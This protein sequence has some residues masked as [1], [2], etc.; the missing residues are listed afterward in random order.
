[1]KIHFGGSPSHFLLYL[2]DLKNAF[3]AWVY[4]RNSNKAVGFD[5]TMFL[6]EKYYSELDIQA[7][8]PEKNEILV[9]TRDKEKNLVL[10]NY[11]SLLYKKLGSGM[12]A[13]RATPDMDAIYMLAERNRYFYYSES[14]LEIIR[15][16]PYDRKKINSRRDLN[17]I[18]SCSLPTG[19]Y[20][21]TYN[22]ELLKLNDGGNFSSP[23]VSLAGAPH[24]PSPDKRKVAAFINGRFYVLNWF[25]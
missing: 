17:A 2:S 16:S 22:G 6:G 10:F 18:L 3:Q 13:A 8:H 19:A 7:F 14:N 5:E 12:L 23:Q 21:S 4:D 15:L 24:Q 1:M 25:D 9:S 20:F 11:R